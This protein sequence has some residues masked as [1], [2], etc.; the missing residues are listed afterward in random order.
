MHYLITPE[1]RPEGLPSGPDHPVDFVRTNLT[2]ASC[3]VF[4]ITSIKPVWFIIIRTF[5]RIAN[6]RY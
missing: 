5:F 6:E 1:S 4:E 3:L 2:N